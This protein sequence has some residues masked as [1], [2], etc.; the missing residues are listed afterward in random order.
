M[1]TMRESFAQGLRDHSWVPTIAVLAVLGAAPFLG[2]GGQWIYF[3]QIASIFALIASGL[4]LSFGYAG[5][6]ALGQ[7]VMFAV[8]A[9]VTGYMAMHGVT[10]L[11]A[12]LAAGGVAAVV[13]GVVTGIPGLRLGHWSLAMISFFLVFTIPD[14]VLLAPGV[15]GGAIGLYGLPSPTLGSLTMSSDELYVASFIVLGIWLFFVRNLMASRNGVTVRMLRA[16]PLL[17]RSLGLSDYRLRIIVYVLGSVPAG[18]AGALFAYAY[19]FVGTSAFGF[20]VSIGVFAAVILG[21]SQTIYGPVIG[22]AVLQGVPLLISGFSRA[23]LLVYG[24]ILLVGGL[25]FRTGL[26]GALERVFGRWLGSWS[27]GQVYWEAVRPGPARPFASGQDRSPA[28]SW[29]FLCRGEPLVL[30]GIRKHY[31]GVNAL[32]GVSLVARPGEVTALVGANGSGKT[33][34]LNVICGFT[35]QDAG[36]VTIGGENVGQLKVF[37]R[38]AFLGRTFQTPIIPGSLSA[39]EVVAAGRYSVERSN[40]VAAV[41]RTR[42]FRRIRHRDVVSASSV[43]KLVGLG[44]VA[45]AS[46]SALPF[47]T[48]RILEIA[49]VLVRQ[50]GVILLDEPA[51]GL[52]DDERQRFLELLETMKVAGATILLVEHN[53]DVVEA[54]ADTAY[55]L[56]LGQVVSSGSLAEIRASA[57]GIERYFGAVAREQAH[58]EPD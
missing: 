52:D 2:I 16:S 6:F 54:A 5:E 33:T 40:T 14:L 21:G 35:K 46:A 48:R 11:I 25:V 49:R 44:G 20:D 26:L 28:T 58:V 57:T 7:I 38:A 50:P 56:D 23:S 42:A 27:G 17:V 4:G 53:M 9:Y 43:L 39:L 8:G 47:G 31:G 32:Q 18:C 3:L 19:Q 22:A 41:L 37:K 30:D 29:Q 24:A 36:T 10:D 34:L 12:G 1:A 55:L 13:I 15:T 45:N 51:A